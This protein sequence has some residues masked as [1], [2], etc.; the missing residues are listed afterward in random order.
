MMKQVPCTVCSKLFKNKHDM[1]LH[2]H[3]SHEGGSA[4]NGGF[5]TYVWVDGKR[6]RGWAEMPS[7]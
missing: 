3:A 5:Y 4:A 1:E 6:F 7:L 2:F